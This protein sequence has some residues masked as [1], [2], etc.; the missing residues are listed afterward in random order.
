MRHH[1]NVRKFGRTKNQ[2]NA[3]LKGLM[4][5]LIAHGRIETTEAKAK[6]L[7]PSIEKLVTK[8][9]VGTLA[10]RR[11]VISRLYNLTAEANKLIDTIAPKYKDRTGGYTR[12]TKLPRRAG[13]ASKMAVIEF[14]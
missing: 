9:N 8:A 4:L 7:R 11:L 3:L 5:A 13:D 6:E 10:S 12:I 14:I 1:S 2:R